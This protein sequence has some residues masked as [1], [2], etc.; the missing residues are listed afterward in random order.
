M[1]LG[2]NSAPT[3]SFR[4]LPT[5]LRRAHS[6]Y[7]WAE[8]WRLRTEVSLQALAL[9][10]TSFQ[11]SKLTPAYFALPAHRVVKRSEMAVPTPAELCD[12]RFGRCGGVQR[13]PFLK[14]E[15]GCYKA[16][17]EI[18]NSDEL[19]RAKETMPK[20]VCDAVDHSDRG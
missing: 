12:Y 18:D 2:R 15:L 14:S 6:P 8:Y 16:K 4:R 17:N 20:T 10:L 7:A 9:S 11:M 5:P 13:S 1:G 3:V 19:E